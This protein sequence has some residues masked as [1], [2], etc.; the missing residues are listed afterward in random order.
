MF[1]F[2]KNTLLTGNYNKYENTI[3]DMMSKQIRNK[4]YNNPSKYNT[5]TLF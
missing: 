2:L 5:L 3:Y 1:N 4:Y